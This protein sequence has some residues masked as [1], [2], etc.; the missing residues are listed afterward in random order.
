MRRLGLIVMF[1]SATA[2]AKPLPKGFTVTLKDHDL[3]ATRDGVTVPLRDADAL[4]DQ[5]DDL[6]GS[7]LSDD[8][9]ILVHV[10]GCGIT[11]DGDPLEVP[12][13]LVDAR[14]ENNL[15]MRAHLKKK[16]DDAIPHFAR[17]VQKDPD[18]AVYATNLLSAQS[19]GKKLDDADKTIAALAK[20]NPAWLGWRLAVDPEL[21]NMKTRESA[22][23]GAPK[24]TKLTFD[25]LGD[26][27]ATNPQGLIAKHD[28]KAWG[29]PGAPIGDDLS[30]YDANSKLLL[31][32]PVTALEDACGDGGM[33]PVPCTKAQ[34]AH[35]AAHDKEAS[36]IL[37]ALGFEKKLVTW[38]ESTGDSYASADKKL[39][40]DFGND[41]MTVTRGKSKQTF[42][43]IDTPKR[44]G[45]AGDIV[46]LQYRS[47]FAACDGDAQRGFTQFVR[48]KP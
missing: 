20:S 15:G 36:A 10:Q 18:T 31:R 1:L 22:K 41:G 9:K 37:G 28:W 2:A 8:G 40:I 13:D 6:K 45:V 21:G 43:D 38:L 42:K 32:M 39:T 33:M 3:Y 29:G 17:A 19:M 46:V 12:L 5:F 34:K 14:I 25:Q 35:T 27:I 30:I 11:S 7:E 24:P 47:T 16:Y 4:I 44:L 26:N 23:A 48:M